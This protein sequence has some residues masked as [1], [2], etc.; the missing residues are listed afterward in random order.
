MEAALG[1]SLRSSLTCIYLKGNPCAAVPSYVLRVRHL[2]P[3][4][5]QLDDNPVAG[6]AGGPPHSSIV[7]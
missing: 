3:K 6:S 2:L 1:P 4:L 7:L 5:E